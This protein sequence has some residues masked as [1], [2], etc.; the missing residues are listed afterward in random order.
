MSKHVF[1]M[2]PAEELVR[3]MKDCLINDALQASVEVKLRAW[4]EVDDNE[5]IVS[6]KS[7][8]KRGS[9]TFKCKIPRIYWDY[10]H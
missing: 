4:C 2:P 1:F 8:R 10:A 7:V 9:V 5:L 6:I 3:R